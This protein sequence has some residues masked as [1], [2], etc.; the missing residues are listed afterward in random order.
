[1]ARDDEERVN[2]DGAL[3]PGEHEPSPHT[4]TSPPA[5]ETR[6]LQPVSEAEED[7][8]E[9]PPWN[10]LFVFPVALLALLALIALVMFFGR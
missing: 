5:D 8:P 6:D 1:M 2:T 9:A 4:K 7:D 3:P 10:F